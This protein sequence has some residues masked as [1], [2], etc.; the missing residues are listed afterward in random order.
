M[1]TQLH[2]KLTQIALDIYEKRHKIELDATFKIA[3]INGTKAEDALSL[4]RAWNWHFYYQN[5]YIKKRTKILRMYRTSEHIFIKRIKDMQTYLPNEL[6][7]YENMGRVIHHIQDMN[8][9]SH[10]VPIYHDMFYHDHFESFM[11]DALNDC[12]LDPQIPQTEEVICDSLDALYHK[13]AK[14]TF[15][16][17]NTTEL[18]VSPN[19][20]SYTFMLN[21][22]WQ[23]YLLQKDPKKSGFGSFGNACKIFKRTSGSST[24][25]NQYKTSF[26]YKNREYTV[27]LDE[28][29]H[30]N[31]QICGRAIKDTIA[32]LE[33]MKL[34]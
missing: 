14:D 15:V 11:L 9:P 32:V 23:D 34:I 24:Y 31:N 29:Y 6:A 17:I 28:M 7:Y 12:K 25:G 22:F 19:N 8:T 2:Q 13:A 10:A 5:K 18:K 30:I 21:I 4:A 33:Y 27:A 3:L 26:L 16:F 1:K 20:E